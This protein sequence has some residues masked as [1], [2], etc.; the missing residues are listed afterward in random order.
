MRQIVDSG[1]GLHVILRFAEPVEFR[2]AGERERWGGMYKALQAILP[3]DPNAPGIT[4]VTRALGSINLKTGRAVTCIDPGK[5]VPVEDVVGLFEELRE[6]P[7]ETVQQILF[8]SDPISP[9][10]ICKKAGTSLK[11]MGH[12]G[13]CYGCGKVGLEHLY[14]FFLKPKNDA[15]EA[16]APVDHG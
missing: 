14:D 12:S 1:R 4:A 10:P 13:R 8:G 3:S 15:T 16:L 2:T 6:A 9:C 7:F 5:P 11:A